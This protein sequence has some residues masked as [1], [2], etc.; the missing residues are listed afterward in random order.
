MK[1]SKL[2]QKN[3]FFGSFWQFFCLRPRIPQDFVNWKTLLRYICRKFHQYSNCSCEIKNFQSFLY[4]FSI[5]EMAPFWDFLDPYSPKYCLIL[6]KLWP[7]VVSN[8]INTVWKLLPNLEFWLK[9]NAVKVTQFAVGKP[10]ILLK[11]KIF[12]KTASLGI[13]N[14]TSSRSQKSHR[15][16]VKL[17]Q[18]TFSGSKLGL[19]YHHGS[20][21]HHKFS[22]SL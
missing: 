6:L 8:K 17:R 14:N 10:K 13:I 18:K 9:W 15:I 22:H 20:K 3:D 5:H 11:N 2:G 21:G 4:W 1:W 19:N 16:L 7:E 12:A